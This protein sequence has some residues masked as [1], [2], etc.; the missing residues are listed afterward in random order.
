MF[1]AGPTKRESRK[2]LRT[3]MYRWVPGNK[4]RA[5]TEPAPS[6]KI[7]ATGIVLAQD[8]QNPPMPEVGVLNRSYKV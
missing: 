2:F 7:K 6:E 8:G 3:C 5:M 1:V 4:A